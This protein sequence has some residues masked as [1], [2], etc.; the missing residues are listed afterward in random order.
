MTKKAKKTP[1]TL[2]V[3]INPDEAMSVALARKVIQPEVMAAVT[4]HCFHDV[5]ISSTSIDIKD[6]VNALAAQVKQVHDGD[7]TT[8]ETMLMSQAFTLDA[9]FGHLARRARIQEHMPNY[10]AFMRL[11]L[12]TQ[13]QCRMTLETL[14][15]IKNPPVIFAKQANIS[16]G[17]QQV[18]NGVAVSH[19]AEN[20]KQS[21]ELL[22]QTHGERL[23]SGTES[24]AIS[25]NS[26]LEAV[27]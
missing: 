21:N 11:A 8:A 5:E 9:L 24:E 20:Q 6:R 26:E 25:V 12:R 23:D 14:S 17:H 2:Q 27:G 15:N 3:E 10:E 18:N 19:T 1:N 13:N 4:Q 22:E 7:M 16:N